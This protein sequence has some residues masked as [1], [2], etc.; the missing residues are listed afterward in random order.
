MDV[1]G[2]MLAMT[3]EE[4]YTRDQY[5]TVVLTDIVPPEVV[6]DYNERNSFSK[7]Y[8]GIDYVVYPQQFY[9]MRKRIN[10]ADEKI[11][12]EMKEIYTK[13]QIL[14]WKKLVKK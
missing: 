9:E 1:E 5:D 2:I 10:Y 4:W 13:E 11:E 7:N 6:W 8:T 14:E 3:K 12:E